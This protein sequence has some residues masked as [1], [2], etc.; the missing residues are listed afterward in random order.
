MSCDVLLSLLSPDPLED[1]SH[2][3]PVARCVR[4]VLKCDVLSHV[5]TEVVILRQLAERREHFTD[6]CAY[7]HE[8]FIINCSQKSSPG[9]V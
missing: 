9:S 4:K 5:F 1:A 2:L 3:V 6:G 8:E 7:K